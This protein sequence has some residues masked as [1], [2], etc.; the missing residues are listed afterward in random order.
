MDYVK[1]KF[2]AYGNEKIFKMNLVI[3]QITTL[4]LK[5]SPKSKPTKIV[6]KI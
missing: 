1:K 4:G 5:I 2:R 6:E 3:S